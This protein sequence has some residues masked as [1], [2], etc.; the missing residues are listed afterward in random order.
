MLIIPP[1]ILCLFIAT[2][3][4]FLPKIASYSVHFAII[5]FVISLSFLIALSSVMHFFICKTSINPRDFKGTTKLVSTG[6]FRFSRNPMYLSLLLML[7]AWVLWLGNSLAWLGIIVFVLA[8][9][10]FQ[11]AKEEAYLENKFGDEYRRYKQKV[12]R[13]L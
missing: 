9:N 1:P 5:A 11:I 10:Q 4:Y 3:M 2:T 6:I 7:I 12:R 13:W 8:I